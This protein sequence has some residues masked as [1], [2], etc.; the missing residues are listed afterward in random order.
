[1]VVRRLPKGQKPHVPIQ[2]VF[3]LDVLH[4]HQLRVC[5]LG[6]E[7]NVKNHV[8]YKKYE[9]LRGMIFEKRT[10]QIWELLLDTRFQGFCDFSKFS[11]V[12]LISS[13]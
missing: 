6:N 12:R 7:H 1:M 4:R 5:L 8:H 13:S 11:R 10:M 2:E 9:K 3:P